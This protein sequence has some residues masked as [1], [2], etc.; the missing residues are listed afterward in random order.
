MPM[1]F[2]DT[3]AGYDFAT[4]T[5]PAISHRLKELTEA[6]EKLAGAQNSARTSAVQEKE[7]DAVKRMSDAFSYMADLMFH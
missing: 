4:G 7:D 1:S 2:W 5:M 3:Q 6:V